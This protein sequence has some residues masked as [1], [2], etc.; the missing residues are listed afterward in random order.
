MSSS[1]SLYRCAV[2]STSSGSLSGILDRDSPVQILPLSVDLGGQQLVDGIEIDNRA[3][4]NWRQSHLDEAVSTMPPSRDLLKK[5]FCYL[6]KL[7]YQQVIVTTLSHTLSDTAETVRAL[8]PDFPKLEIHVVDTG[9]CCMPEGFFALEALRLLGDGKTPQEV[10]D[11]LERLKPNSHIFFGLRSL[12]SLSLNGTLARLGARFSDW[13]GFRTILHFSE[14]ELSRLGSVSDDEEMFD[15]II[16]STQK[17]MADKN[18]HH[19]VLAGMYSGEP[20]VYAR[21]AARFHRKTGLHLGEG[22]PVS[23]A[24]AVHVGICGVGVGLVEKL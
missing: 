8:I 10:V 3:Y 21:F 16:D 2:M 24:V 14:G 22:V 4:Y 5:L 23:P 15:A 13:L 20:E 6:V 19:F 12:Q 17:Q 18:P 11:Y 1:Y 9:T 7:G